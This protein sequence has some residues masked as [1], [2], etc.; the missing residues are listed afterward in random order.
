MKYAALTQ[1]VLLAL[2]LASFSGLAQAE[3]LQAA[4][5]KAYTN[6]PQLK[7]DQARVRATDE[8]VA[9]ARAGYRPTLTGNASIART[10]QTRITTTDGGETLHPRTAS[11]QVRQPV[12]RGFRTSAAV[13]GAKS[14]VAQARAALQGTEQQVL[15]DAAT[16]YVNVYRDQAIAALRRTNESFLQK[17]LEGT[18]DRFQAGEVTRTD[19]SQAESRLARAT[20][21]RVQA[22]GNFEISK[23]NYER[24]VGDQPQLLQKPEVAVPVPQSLQTAIEMAQQNSPNV[25]AAEHAVDSAKEQIVAARG[26]LLPEVNLV[27]SMQ[28]GYG[29]SFIGPNKTDS[30]SIGAQLTMPLYEGGAD[31]ARTRAAKQTLSQRQME[32]DD[33]INR[34]KEGAIRA[35]QLLTSTQAAIES[36]KVQVASASL[37]LEGVKQEANVGTRTTLDVLDAEQELLDAKVAMVTAESD[38]MTAVF[39]THAAVGQMT[40]TALK[41]PVATYDPVAYYDDNAGKWVGLGD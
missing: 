6:N 39:Q 1:S 40:A 22:E 31:Y 21:D 29:T 25:Q 5:A 9:V 32:L 23:A 34:A 41:L 15:V 11:V 20:A 33:A 8:Q 10:E 19:V 7:A 35:W 26:S 18:K 13:D 38:A 28:R 14:D 4:L 36:R 17:Q 27:G 3:T 24:L 12:F 16:A 30:N 2:M 37:A